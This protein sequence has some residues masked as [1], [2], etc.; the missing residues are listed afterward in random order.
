MIII[1]IYRMME[2]DLYNVGTK[3]EPAPKGVG[4]DVILAYSSF[5]FYVHRIICSYSIMNFHIME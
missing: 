2:N 3:K 5:S 1:V 4:S